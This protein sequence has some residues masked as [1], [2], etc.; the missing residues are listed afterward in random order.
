MTDISTPNID[1]IAHDGVRFT[2]GYMVSTLCSVS[3][4]GILT[5]R[6]PMR[7]GQEFNPGPPES[8]DSAFGIPPEVPTLAEQL[9][10]LGY[11]T[12]IF[13]KWHLGYLTPNLPTSRG[14]DEFYGFLG[15]SHRYNAKPPFRSGRLLEGTASVNEKGPLTDA[16]A[17]EAVRFIG[18][19]ASR[20]FFLYVPFN[21][22]HAPLEGDARRLD[23]VQQIENPERRTYA[24]VL[25]AMDDAVGQIL[26]AIDDHNL[27]DGTLVIFVSD[28]GGPTQSTTSSKRAIASATASSAGAASHGSEGVSSCGESHSRPLSGL[29]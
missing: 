29:K 24:A 12:A 18:D 23:R 10:S 28:N 11:R 8:G 17:R 2:D 13:G 6:Y 27:R 1:A 22:V 9:R 25:A 5:G 26:K 21:A 19:N 14:F 4:G 7:W 16:F 3:R 20:P 15:A